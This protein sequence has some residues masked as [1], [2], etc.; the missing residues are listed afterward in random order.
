M[1]DVELKEAAVGGPKTRPT[2]R[3]AVAHAAGSACGRRAP[4]GC[5]QTGECSVGPR[6]PAGVTVASRR[7]CGPWSR[8]PIGVATGSLGWVRN[9]GGSA[10]LS[11]VLDP[12]KGAAVQAVRTGEHDP[13]GTPF[14]FLYEPVHGV[15]VLAAEVAGV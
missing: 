2:R 4:T 1:T 13:L 5:P 7:R 12:S 10:L 9:A 3:I 11:S 6:T 14:A 15:V 8:R